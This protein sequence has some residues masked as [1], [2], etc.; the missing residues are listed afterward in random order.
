MSDNSVFDILN[1]ITDKENVEKDMQEIGSLISAH[2]N[3]KYLAPIEQEIKC[4]NKECEQ[5]PTNEISLLRALKPFVSNTANI[6]R[7][8]K[9]M[10]YS[11][12][13]QKLQTSYVI[14]SKQDS[15]IHNDGI[16]DVDETCLINTLGFG[17]DSNLLLV[18]LIVLILLGGNNTDCEKK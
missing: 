13:F 4:C 15:S 11:R 17:N 12:T 1:R 18:A 10:N 3:N 16:Y 9:A 6:D 5:S 8:I 14:Q 7:I 2:I